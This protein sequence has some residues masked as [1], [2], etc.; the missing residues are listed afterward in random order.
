MAP[1]LDALLVPPL[2][3]QPLVENAVKYGI[4]QMQGP[5]ELVIGVAEEPKGTLRL[6]VENTVPA[7]GASQ[8]AGLGIGL[9]NVAHRL[10]ARWPGQCSC[11]ATLSAQNRFTVQITLPMSWGPQ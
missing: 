9:E 1:G 5:A 3:L 2:I 7:S 11:E 10:Q 4:S 6:W 8:T